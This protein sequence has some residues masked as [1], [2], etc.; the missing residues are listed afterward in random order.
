MFE[1]I[2]SLFKKVV[3]FLCV[4]DIIACPI[5]GF[6]WVGLAENSY[7]TSF[8]FPSAILGAFLGLVFVFFWKL[9][10]APILVLFEINDKLEFICKNIGTQNKST[11]IEKL[12]VANKNEEETIINIEKPAVIEIKKKEVTAEM[13]EKANSKD[14]WICPNCG[15]ENINKR[16]VCSNCGKEKS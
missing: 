5:L 1:K 2:I 12:N 16:T 14:C 3:K 8:S 15:E 11:I 7:K 9:L 13:I 6:I 10:L 4:I